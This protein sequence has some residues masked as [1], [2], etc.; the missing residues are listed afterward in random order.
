MADP[1]RYV[2]AVVRGLAPDALD[3]ATG[4]DGGRLELVS[5]RGLTAVVSSVDLEEYGEAGLR[6]NLEDLGWLERVA[7]GHDA[8]VQAAAAG[9]PTAPLRLATICLDD[10]G[11]VERLDAWHD[12]LEEVL[13]RVAD[14]VEWSVKVY[15]ARRPDAPPSGSAPAGSGAAYLQRK[16]AEARAAR[17]EE[18]TSLLLADEVHQRLVG[19]SVASRRLAAQDPRLTGR[20]ERMLHNGAYLVDA[21]DSD[22]FAAAIDEIVAGNPDVVVEHEGPW[23]PYSFATLE[24]S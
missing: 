9:A 16:Q 20:A 24:Q 14:R 12:E 23:P 11:V 18:T 3:G 22:R 19:V 15:A 13:D 2:Y 4:L 17:A 21:D 6:A 7:R 5:H 1:G 8:V 10:A